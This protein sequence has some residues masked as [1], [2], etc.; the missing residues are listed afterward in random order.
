MQD[1]MCNNTGDYSVTI[2][3]FRC[4]IKLYLMPFWLLW[5]HHRTNILCCRVLLCG[6][7]FGKHAHTNSRAS[8]VLD[9]R[10]YAILQ[11]L[12]FACSAKIARLRFRRRGHNGASKAKRLL[13]FSA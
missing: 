7:V 11:A 2:F 4:S 8:P 9:V 6:L 3:S 12:V 1:E 13:G 5:T 10:H